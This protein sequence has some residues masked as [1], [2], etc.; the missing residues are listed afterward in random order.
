[1]VCV[2]IMIILIILMMMEMLAPMNNNNNN[3]SV[4]N[5]QSRLMI[6]ITKIIEN[7]G[8]SGPARIPINVLG[9]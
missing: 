2:M 4:K 7:L 9:I 5:L 8:V 6:I 3:N 1:M